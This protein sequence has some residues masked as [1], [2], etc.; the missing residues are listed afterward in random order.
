M[1]SPCHTL[2][3][4]MLFS[5]W[6]RCL[7][8]AGLLIAVQAGILLFL[9][10][11]LVCTCG[12]IKFWEGAV[13]SIG[14]SQHL[15]DWYTF[16]HLIH[17]F[18]FYLAVWAVFPRMPVAQRFAIAL[19]I[20]VGWEVMENTPW[21]I[22]HYREQALAAGYM[23]DSIINSVS[24]TLAMILGFVLAWR[25]PVWVTLAV[26][27]AIEVGVGYAIHDGFILNVLNFIHPFDFIREWQSTG[28]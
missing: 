23:G 9:G 3:V 21:V 12:Y 8:A 18:L 16:S 17:G 15:T 14:N 7:I 10:Q 19:G 13:F 22:D 1:S 2:N 4:H 20:E 26:A 25:L 28:V 11:P 6:R 27:A 5:S 24:D